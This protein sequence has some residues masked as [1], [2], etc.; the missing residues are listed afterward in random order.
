MSGSDDEDN[1]KGVPVVKQISLMSVAAQEEVHGI[2][3]G[4]LQDGTPYLTARGLARLCGVV[5]SVVLEL[6]RNWRDLSQHPRGQQIWSS[7]EEQGQDPSYLYIEAQH[8]GKK[9]N[10]HPV[11]VCIAF[12][13]YYAFHTEAPKEEA[14]LALRLF[15][16]KSLGEL[17][18]ER[19]GY[20]PNKA[21]EKAWDYYKEM[22]TANVSPPGYFSVFKE[23]S[24][25]LVDAIRAGLFVSPSTIP[26]ISVGQMWAK[27]WKVK[28]LAEEFGDRKLHLHHYPSAYP[29]SKAHPEANV[30]PNGALGEF[31]RWMEEE[32]LPDRFPKYLQ[33]KSK[34]N[35]L[36]E[37][38]VTAL[39]SQIQSRLL[40]SD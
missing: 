34:Q 36:T 37:D 9:I 27:H 20:N 15:A 17:I 19:V 21:L 2:E 35:L 3:M 39:L 29:Q 12:A 38:A 1:R 23:C 6:D 30:Y 5:Y 25:L 8:N 22:V 26:D 32:Y 4:V 40:T 33:R 11:W 24:E 14:R 13:E 31:R 16:Q 28:N 18:Y 10:A 7:I